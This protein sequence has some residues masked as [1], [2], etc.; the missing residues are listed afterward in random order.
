[1]NRNFTPENFED[2]LKEST[3]GFRLKAP[4]RVWQNLSK[5][6]NK[7]RRR[8]ITSLSVLLLLTSTA[9]YYLLTGNVQEQKVNPNAGKQPTT[10]SHQAL[11][12]KNE[13]AETSVPDDNGAKVVSLQ[14]MWQS[15]VSIFNAKE[16]TGKTL[17]PVIDITNKTKAGDQSIG[18]T[19]DDAFFQN[20]F[21]STIVDSDP[22]QEAQPKL[23]AVENKPATPETTDALPLTIESVLNAYKSKHTGNRFET[24]LYFTPTVSYR[25]LTENKSYLRGLN[26]ASMPL[27]YPALSSSVNSHVTHKPDVGFELGLTIKHSFSNHV[28]IRSGVQFN[29]N[30]YDVKAFSSSGSIATIALNNGSRVDSLNTYSRYSNLSGYKSDWLQNLSFQVSMP[31]GIEYIVKG[32]EKTHFGIAATVQPTYV[33]GDRAY[34]ITTD[35]KSYTE[36]P[37]L[38]RRWNVNTS[39][40]TFVSYKRWQFGPQVRYQLLSSFE[41]KYPVKENLFDFGLKVGVRL[42]K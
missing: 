19:G 4:D 26:P 41:S 37:W 28:K 6:L 2:F 13:G 32:D 11:A 10:T 36:V 22:E 1:M 40:E 15:S 39:L 17:A 14:P 29:V 23:T 30:R 31:L 16:G 3:D 38:T 42:S 5:E 25:K 21:T 34:L 24:Q 20:T 33:L 7:K 27:G 35:Y 18:F 8:F 9:G 12:G